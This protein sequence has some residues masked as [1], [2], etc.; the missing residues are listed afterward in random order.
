[1]KR[2]IFIWDVHGCIAEL[3]LL[4]GEISFNKKRDRLFFTGDVVSKWPC[5]IEVLE[6]I[7]WLKNRAAIVMWNHEHGFCLNLDYLC[8]K[9]DTAPIRWKN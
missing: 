8:S 9:T 7:K 3:E 1:M 4:L 6:L 2:D 5:S